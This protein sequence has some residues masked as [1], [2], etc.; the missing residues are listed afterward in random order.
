MTEG[1]RMKGARVRGKAFNF[2]EEAGERGMS[3]W[4]GKSTLKRA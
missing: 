2:V 1:D 4:K 3:K